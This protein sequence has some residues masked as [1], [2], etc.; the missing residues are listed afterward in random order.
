MQLLHPLDGLDLP[1]EHPF[2]G[3]GGPHGHGETI[4]LKLEVKLES[5]TIMQL[6]NCVPHQKPPHLWALMFSQSADKSQEMLSIAPLHTTMEC[7]A[8]DGKLHIAV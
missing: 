3:Q 8:G 1:S 2:T 5:Y 6:V 7:M 4:C